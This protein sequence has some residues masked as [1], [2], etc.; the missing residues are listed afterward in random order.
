MK[1]NIHIDPENMEPESEAPKAKGNNLLYCLTGR[2][3]AAIAIQILIEQ[4]GI[5]KEIAAAQIMNKRY[6]T[7]DMAVWLF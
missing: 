7:R 4:K 5:A 2:M 6:E 3:S 1:K